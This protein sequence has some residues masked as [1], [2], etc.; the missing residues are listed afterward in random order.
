VTMGLSRKGQEPPLG[1]RQARDGLLRAVR[2][3]VFAGQRQDA[4]VDIGR[5][6]HGRRVVE[7]LDA[8]RP[9]P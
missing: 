3:W 1:G 6:G 4:G 9:D 8:A 5:L 7:P 2:G